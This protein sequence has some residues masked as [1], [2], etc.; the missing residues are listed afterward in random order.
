MYGI[1]VKGPFYA[2]FI[3]DGTKTIETR[4]RDMLKKLV[5]ERV[6]V[7]NTGIWKRPR[8]IGYVTITGKWY[9]PDDKFDDYFY[10]HWVMA[11][12][13]FYTAG[14]GKWMYELT[15][16]EELPLVGYELPADAVR[17]GRSWCEFTI[18]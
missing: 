8:V 4:S 14:R 3:C 12:D 17:H 16:P 18:N 7:I 13:E 2:S 11:G 5:G 9:C 15:D 6:A 1:F 10:K